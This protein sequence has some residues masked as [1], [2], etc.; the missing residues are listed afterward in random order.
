MLPFAVALLFILIGI[1]MILFY[2]RTHRPS[3]DALDRA[4]DMEGKWGGIALLLGG[5]VMLV[6]LVNRAI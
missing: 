6:V 2:R 5:V 4:L 3:G 1:A